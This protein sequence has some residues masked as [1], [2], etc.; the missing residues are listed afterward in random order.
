M[1]G[2]VGPDRECRLA[3]GDHFLGPEVVDIVEAGIQTWRPQLDRPVAAGAEHG[4]VT[5]AGDSGAGDPGRDANAGMLGRCLDQQVV[6]TRPISV[7]GDD[8]R[9]EGAARHECHAGAIRL[10]LDHLGR[11]P[12]LLRVVIGDDAW[13]VRVGARDLDLD[14]V[15]LDVSANTFRRGVDAL[16]PVPAVTDPFL[17]RLELRERPPDGHRDDRRIVPGELEHPGEVRIDIPRPERGDPVMNVVEIQ[18]A[19]LGLV[20]RCVAIDQA[21]VRLDRRLAGP[22]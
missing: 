1:G 9:L 22:N 11:D 4:Q 13:C 8:E 6:R 20:V 21:D 15:S 7:G 12:E 17:D 2:L 16:E 3:D 10:D 19:E 14:H 18:P 5:A